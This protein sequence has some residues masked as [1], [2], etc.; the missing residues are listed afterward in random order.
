VQVRALLFDFDGLICDTERAAR[1]SWQELYHELGLSFPPALWAAMVGQPDGE[2]TALADLSRRLDEPLDDAT[3][4]RRRERKFALCQ[5]EP[6]RPGVAE[7]MTAA[8]GVG[9]TLAV[10]SSSPFA[11]VHTHLVRLGIQERIDIVIT[12]DDVARPKPAPD[13]YW[14]ALERSAVPAAD[15]LA[16]EDSP[17][18]VRAASAAGVRCIAVASAVGNRHELLFADMVLDSLASLTLEA[19]DSS[20]E[21][22]ATR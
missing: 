14:A 20:L 12:G 9:L 6:L 11:W 7:L 18:G 5:L 21:L 19:I 22:K 8:G 15:A 2:T 1:R 3:R 13:L 17:I 4:T 10:V 16:F